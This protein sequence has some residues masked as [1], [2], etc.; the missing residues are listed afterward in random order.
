[1][2]W[3]PVIAR[4]LCVLRNS[5]GLSVSQLEDLAGLDAEVVSRIEQQVQSPTVDM[6]EVLAIALN[7]ELPAFFRQ[8]I[9]FRDAD[10]IF[11]R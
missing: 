2:N 6:L 9:A 8:P 5:A 4:N 3:R 7:A 11:D 10:Q 1:M